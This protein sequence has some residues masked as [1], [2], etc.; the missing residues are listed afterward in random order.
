MLVCQMQRATYHIFYQKKNVLNV[1]SW[2]DE[3]GLD[4]ALY[5]MK[6]ITFCSRFVLCIVL[7]ESLLVCCEGWIFIAFST[8]NV[9]SVSFVTEYTFLHKWKISL[10]LLCCKSVPGGY[11]LQ[12]H[13]SKHCSKQSLDVLFPSR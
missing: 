10:F 11:L 2:P 4:L 7:N 13:C 5:S 3:E 6:I 12:Q 1:N 9:L 8:S